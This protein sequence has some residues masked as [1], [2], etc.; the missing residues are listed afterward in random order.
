MG[1]RRGAPLPDWLAPHFVAAVFACNVLGCFAFAL[2]ADF[3]RRPPSEA[4]KVPS[5]RA[6][7][8]SHDVFDLLAA[9]GGFG[10][11]RSGIRGVRP[12]SRNFRLLHGGGVFERYFGGF[13]RRKADG[14]GAA[15]Y[16]II[17]ALGAQLRHIF[18]E[19]L[20]SQTFPWG[21]ALSN[22]A[23]C[24][25]VVAVAKCANSGGEAKFLAA[26]F[27]ATLST[28]SSLN[29]GLLKM[30]RARQVLCGVFVLFDFRALRVRRRSCPIVIR[31]GFANGIFC[32][33][34]FAR[35]VC[36]ARI[37]YCRISV[38]IPHSVSHCK[39]LEKM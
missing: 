21:I 22:I 24:A 28:F 16:I 35:G 31:R 14:V 38:P 4:W 18:A 11:R 29:Y 34:K 32:K 13:C 37:F 25:I 2:Y 26:G 3:E 10:R 5:G 1:R 20:D 17:S 30:L 6:M 27:A 12:V 9:S 8:R 7:R 19:F 33:S 36:G 39:V 15:A 23:A